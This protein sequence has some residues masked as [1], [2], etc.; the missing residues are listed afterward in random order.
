MSTI[1]LDNLLHSRCQINRPLL[2]EEAIG[3]YKQIIHPR[4][5]LKKENTYLSC[6]VPF[7]NYYETI[8]FVNAIAWIAHEQNHHPDLVVKYKQCK[9]AFST[10][11]AGGITKNDFICAAKIDTLLEEDE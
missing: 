9:I 2:S 10:H 7:K 8:A 11:D 4:W 3:Q 5:Q 1:S 6:K